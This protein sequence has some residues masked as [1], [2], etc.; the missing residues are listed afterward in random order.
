MAAS[1][2]HI[3][4][5]AVDGLQDP[6]WARS[7]TKA[8]YAKFGSVFVAARIFSWPDFAA[9]VAKHVRGKVWGWPNF[10]V[11]RVTNLSNTPQEYHAQGLWQFSPLKPPFNPD[12]HLDK[13]NSFC[14]YY[15][16]SFTYY[17]CIIY[18][19]FEGLLIW[20]KGMCARNV[21]ILK[22]VFL[23]GSLAVDGT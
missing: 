14:C 6:S 8:C 7:P 12:I 13:A 3:I 20:W 18:G 5:G 21:W 17:I 4:L 15:K 2:T 19:P 22:P 16:S 23:L 11:W 10:E 9:F 1:F